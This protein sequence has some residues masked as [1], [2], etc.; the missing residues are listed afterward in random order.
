MLGWAGYV[1]DRDK[2]VNSNGEKGHRGRKRDSN[3]KIKLMKN[4]F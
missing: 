1:D 2:Y 3:I 4:V